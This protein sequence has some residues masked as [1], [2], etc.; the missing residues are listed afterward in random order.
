M[1]LNPSASAPAP[2]YRVTCPMCGSRGPMAA[3]ARGACMLAELWGW[4][5]PSGLC[6]VCKKMG[7]GLQAVA[8]ETQ[9]P[10]GDMAK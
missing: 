8:G 5:D 9:A 4:D 2:V 1:A 6:I 10:E 3:T 7:D